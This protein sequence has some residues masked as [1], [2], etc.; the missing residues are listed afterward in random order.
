MGNL[1]FGINFL[2]TEN[3]I[4]EII[5]QQFSLALLHVD[6]SYL[7]LWLESFWFVFIE[8][9][10]GLKEDLMGNDTKWL[11]VSPLI[12]SPPID[13]WNLVGRIYINW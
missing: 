10:W 7:L 9:R 1:K 13:V 11:R 6:P 4:L 12:Y 8:E 2:T 5:Y 3:V